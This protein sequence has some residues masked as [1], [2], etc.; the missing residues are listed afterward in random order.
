M[1]YS[2]TATAHDTTFYLVLAADAVTMELQKD[3]HA[4]IGNDGANK[5]EELTQQSTMAADLCTM[6]VIGHILIVRCGQ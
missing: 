1:N 5:P 6:H 2:R 4:P 3:K